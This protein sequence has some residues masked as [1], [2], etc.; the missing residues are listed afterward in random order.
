MKN[1]GRN[2]DFSFILVFVEG[3]GKISV[4]SKKTKNNFSM[5]RFSENVTYCE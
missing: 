5:L 3:R 2:S 4:L 1:K